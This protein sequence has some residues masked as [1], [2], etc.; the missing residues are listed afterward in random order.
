MRAGIRN[1]YFKL[2]SAMTDKVSGDYDFGHLTNNYQSVFGNMR[3]DTFD[4][5]YFPTRGFTLGIG[6]EWIFHG[7]NYHVDPFHSLTF[8]VKAVAQTRGALAIIPSLQA[9]YLFGGD[10]TLP[11]VN[12][13]G[14]AIPGRYL[15]QQMTFTGINYATACAN[16][17]AIARTD[18][19]FKLFKNNYLTAMFNYAVTVAEIKDFG[20]VDKTKGV[21][22]TGYRRTGSERLLPVITVM[23][24]T[25]F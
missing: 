24:S 8:D 13:M 1:N 11:Y 9:R 2:N 16:F 23:S 12:V 18:F 7:T 5:G 21:F 19:R 15:D 25:F 17:L 10:P 22:G 14:G 3:A 6:Y 4:D 20:N